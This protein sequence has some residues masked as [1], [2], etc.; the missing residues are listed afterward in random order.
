MRLVPILLTICIIFSGLGYGTI[1]V[2]E[3]IVNNCKIKIESFYRLKEK[4]ID[5]WENISFLSVETGRCI[6]E[7]DGI[8]YELTEDEVLI[9]IDKNEAEQE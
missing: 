7:L 6:V 5:S 3:L 4:T 8:W 1:K 2:N 9:L